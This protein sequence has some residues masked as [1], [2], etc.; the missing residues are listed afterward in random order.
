VVVRSFLVAIGCLSVVLGVIGIFLPVM[1]TT[2]FLLLAAA[3]FARSSPRFY[4]WLMSN[5]WFGP[6]LR[7][8]TEGLGIPLKIKVR[9][10]GLLWL[11]MGTSIIFFVPMLWLKLA[12][13]AVALGASMYIWFQPTAPAITDFSSTKGD[14]QQ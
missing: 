14:A 4:H 13:A 3:C 2:P 10:I 9:V 11:T 8:Y 7:Y 1:P 12:M 6:Y 5:R